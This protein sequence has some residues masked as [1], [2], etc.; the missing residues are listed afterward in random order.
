MDTKAV[1]D[2]SFW[3]VYK[4]NLYDDGCT[5]EKSIIYNRDFYIVKMCVDK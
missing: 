3:Y 2:K 1:L 5:I 4:M